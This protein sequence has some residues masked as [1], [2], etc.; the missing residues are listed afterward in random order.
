MRLLLLWARVHV[1]AW[2]RVAA[3]AFAATM[4]G[5]TSSVP[6]A[7]SVPEASS[8][9]SAR[10]EQALGDGKVTFGEYESSFRDFVNCAAVKGY[11][12]MNVHLSNQVYEY[13]VTDAAHTSAEF[14]ACYRYQFL[15]VD[16]TWQVQHEDDSD[17][18]DDV[19]QC[20]KK[21]GVEP[22][23]KLADNVVL[24]DSNG[25]DYPACV[26]AP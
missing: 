11:T 6:A 13:V 20:L 18:N 2:Q 19:M 23:Q 21:W 12:L 15:S 14:D 8:A 10:Q 26:K 24:L 7:E 17:T 16:S 25:I 3:A 4:T 1:K 5:C 9:M 22:A